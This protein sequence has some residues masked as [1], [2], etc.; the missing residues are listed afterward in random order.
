M[1]HRKMIAKNL[2][3]KIRIDITAYVGQ[4]PARIRS[5]SYSFKTLLAGILLLLATL[6]LFWIYPTSYT[7]KEFTNSSEIVLSKEQQ[8]EF[9]DNKTPLNISYNQDVENY[10]QLFLTS[11]SKDLTL[12]LARSEYYFPIIESYLDR[13]NLPLEL[14]YLAVVE[15]GLNPTA[16]SSSGAAGIW[17]FLYAT[18]SLVDLNVTSYIDE[19]YDIYKS[20]DAACRYLKYLH[21][22]FG[23]W[24]LAMAAYNGGP[25]PVRDAVKLSEGNKD[26]W[27]IRHL[28]S[29]ETA[30]YIP[31]I[32]AIAYLFEYP[33]EFDIN[34]VS[35]PNL[36]NHLDTIRVYSELKLDRI[37][38]FLD[39]PPDRL[40]TIN[41][42]YKK[43]VIPKNTHGY[44]LVLPSEKIS[45]FRRQYENIADITIR[46][47]KKREKN[48][49]DN[50]A[51]KTLIVHVVK[52]GEFFHKLAMQYN[53]SIENI[54]Q[55]NNL[56]TNALFPGQKLRIWIKKEM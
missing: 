6:V 19:R 5:L 51:D 10:I 37:G 49:I 35:L 32:S 1:T 14:K 30:N 44:P 9:L 22:I 56:D 20:T 55:W 42:I 54:K 47:P 34:Q 23:N 8:F 27:E 52:K 2:L 25:G 38:S 46:I 4:I 48:L 39:I 18:C 53:C 17:Q 11:R 16:V 31:A 13:Y 36:Y 50:K 41:P 21:R 12:F 43:G 3:K 29:E 7:Q 28:L 40:N 24:E 26:F 33:E 15:S 45:A